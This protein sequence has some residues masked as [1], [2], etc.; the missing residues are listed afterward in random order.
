MSVNDLF[1][2]FAD[3]KYPPSSQDLP[4]Q[5]PRQTEAPS[6]ITCEGSPCPC[7]RIALTLLTPWTLALPP[8]P[9][10]PGLPHTA[11]TPARDLRGA[12]GSGEG[13]LLSLLVSVTDRHTSLVELGTLKV[14][15]NL[16]YFMVDSMISG[17]AMDTVHTGMKVFGQPKRGV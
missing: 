13:L 5:S 8:A 7:R 10:A 15:H 6:D 3:T 17:S 9:A 4:P 2:I 11:V 1:V 14:F 16:N 12:A